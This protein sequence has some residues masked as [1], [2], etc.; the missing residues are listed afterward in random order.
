LNGT[1]TC[2]VVLTW[3]GK[4]MK[5]GLLFLSITFTITFTIT[6]AILLIA[7]ASAGK[8]EDTISFDAAIINATNNFSANLPDGSRVAVL[9]FTSY[10]SRFSD[11]VIEEL[12]TNLVNK[13]SFIVV[14]RKE[15][16]IVSK[17]L[18][19]QASG[20]VSDESAQS[21]GK[22]LGAEYVISGSIVDL[23]GFYRM[24]FVAINVET[25]RR[26]AASS[27]DISA[28]DRNISAFFARPD[29]SSSSRKV[30]SIDGRWTY[31]IEDEI[32]IILEFNGE[33]YIFSI[34]DA[35]FSKQEFEAHLAGKQTL[36]FDIVC[37]GTVTL[38]DSTMFLHYNG[39]ETEDWP[40]GEAIYYFLGIELKYKI[41]GDRLIVSGIQ[42]LTESGNVIFTK[43]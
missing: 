1:V 3:G 40:E 9:N 31:F 37:L 34:S 23:K 43:N 29:S 6:L 16:N 41:S 36:D 8:T 4:I 5:K 42:D 21:I 32:G 30:S 35:W 22:M 28:N 38:T 15:L 25:A 39:E 7:C 13:S 10:S 11:F 33:D 24:R 2:R 20:E 27:Y 12:Y 17:E 18:K 26:E 14:D 19:F